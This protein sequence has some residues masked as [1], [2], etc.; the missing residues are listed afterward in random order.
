M[1][2]VLGLL[3]LTI[4]GVRLRTFHEPLERDLVTYLLIGHAM[5]Q[6]G[7]LYV[8]AWDIKPPGVYEL[9]AWTEAAVGF[10][11]LQLY[12]LGVLTA[13]VSL[14]GAYVA[15][16]KLGRSAGLWS[17]LFWTLLCS[18][19]GLQA[20]QPNGEVF[21]NACVIWALALLLHADRPSGGIARAFGVGVCF[22]LGTTFK[23]IVII[24]AFFLCLAHLVFSADL[25]GGWRRALRDLLIIAAVGGLCW[26]G[27][28]AYYAAT[29]R[30]EIFWVGNF[31]NTRAYAGNPLFNVY[32]YVR[33]GRFLP[34]CLWFASPILLVMALA[35]WRGRRAWRTREGAL[36][37][38]A[39]LAVQVKIAL[40]GQGFLPHYYQ[41]WLPIL[42]IGG[43]WAI[44]AKGRE[45]PSGPEIAVPTPDAKTR[46]EGLQT[47]S[48]STW[49]TTTA[50]RVLGVV[51][52][53]WLI[54]AQFQSLVLTSD[55]FSR[56][57]YGESVL[58][59][60]DLGRSIGSL[61]RP[62]ERLYQH[63]DRP[64]L[65]YYSGHA[66]PSL[67]LWTHHLKDHWPVA[68]LLMERHQA[69][70][71][72]APPDLVV[73]EKQGPPPTET[74]ATKGLIGRLLADSAPVDDRRNA[75]SVLE[76]LGPSYLAFEVGALAKYHEFSFLVRKGSDLERRWNEARDEAGP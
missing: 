46:D 66:P 54:G 47:M 28:I 74:R 75:R 18:A 5:N 2:I 43:G 23:Q 34:P 55:E 44:G 21:I 31:A 61:L 49:P 10:G 37:L 41:Y 1:P 70:L 36:F 32:R 20:N 4:A 45:D 19:S 39:V 69:A 29:G 22:A 56:T 15:G 40:N 42:A 35:A 25:P 72:A 26:S 50:M 52:A 57:K 9:Y 71:D 65:Y 12:V 38:A 30:F 67:L 8:D 13:L 7:R 27:L 14:I 62:G 17:A 60:R 68:R 6:G 24:D 48:R 64:E 16:S 51:A 33:E 59:G 63:G 58:E 3:G 76:R 53:L 11:E 73:V